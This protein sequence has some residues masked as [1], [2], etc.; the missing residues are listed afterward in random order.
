MKI[1]GSTVG[2]K[3]I[4]MSDFYNGLVTYIVVI[5]HLQQMPADGW[6]DGC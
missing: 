6:M 2:A 5:G 1:L 4:G 3:I